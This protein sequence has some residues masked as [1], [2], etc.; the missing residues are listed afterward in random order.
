M[1][2]GKVIRYPKLAPFHEEKIH[3]S[4]MGARVSSEIH[5]GKID[6]LAG[7]AG[8]TASLMLRTAGNRQTVQIC[9]GG[10]IRGESITMARS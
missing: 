7:A 2:P 1:H 8:C 4:S 6:V 3:A 9:S 10:D 5:G